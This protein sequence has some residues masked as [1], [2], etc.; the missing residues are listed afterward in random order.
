V[1]QIQP[2]GMDDGAAVP[3]PVQQLPGARR[4]SLPGLP[5]WLSLLLRN[6]K[7][8]IGL[9]LLGGRLVVAIFAARASAAPP[10]HTPVQRARRGN[11]CSAQDG[12]RREA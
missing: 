6:P 3:L 7:S 1:S 4:R 12:Y 2:V 5:L 8:C 10:E 9:V 11:A